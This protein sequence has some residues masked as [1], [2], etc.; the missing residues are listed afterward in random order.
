MIK[1]FRSNNQDCSCS[2]GSDMIKAH[3]MFQGDAPTIYKNEGPLPMGSSQGG[4]DFTQTLFYPSLDVI[5]GEF[6]SALPRVHASKVQADFDAYGNT[7]NLYVAT[8]TNYQGSFDATDPPLIEATSGFTVP[9]IDAQFTPTLNKF[10]LTRMGY[11]VPA[12]LLDKKL[13]PE[14]ASANPEQTRLRVATTNLLAYLNIL[15][16]KGGKL[17]YGDTFDGLGAICDHFNAVVDGGGMDA[18]LAAM[19]LM[20]G[21]S[22]RGDG[23]G[24][25][26]DALVGN[27]PM[28]AALI[29]SPSTGAGRNGLSGWK[30]DKRTGRVLYHFM[31]IPF[32]RA[33]VPVDLV[34][35]STGKST[36]Y[37]VNF[38]SDGLRLIYGYGTAESMGI[39]VDKQSV[40]AANGVSSYLVQGAWTLMVG[41]PHAVHA[42]ENIEVPSAEE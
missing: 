5:P 34:T 24:V 38:G 32:Y 36:L 6:L 30:L 22:P 26:V 35:S 13:L 19:L 11:E 37:G 1:V 31:G 39:Q 3:G 41:D 29:L 16:S 10:F 23:T 17:P 27:N 15:V 14:R 21:I 2:G 25:G 12:L 18:D 33:P 9:V 40:Q 28:L 4:T 42:V 8:Q 20:A 7:Q